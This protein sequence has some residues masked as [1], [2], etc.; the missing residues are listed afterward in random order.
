MPGRVILKPKSHHEI[1]LTVIF[2]LCA[3]STR[4]PLSVTI[5][6][7]R[8]LEPRPMQP[9]MVEPGGGGM[10]PLHLESVCVCVCV[11]GGVIVWFPYRCVV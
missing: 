3:Q 6:V 5:P 9:V 10:P 4:K 2:S 1:M 11:G 8:P 7:Y